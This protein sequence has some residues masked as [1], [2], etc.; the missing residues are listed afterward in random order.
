M[1]TVKF[2]SIYK[3]IGAIYEMYGWC[4]GNIP[5]LPFLY[6]MVKMMIFQ[7]FTFFSYF[8]AFF[9]VFCLKFAFFYCFLTFFH[10]FCKIGV[11]K[12]GYF[13]GIWSKYSGK[14]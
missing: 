7:F 13:D 3:G 11:C 4:N 12:M 14:R 8:D 6:I 9:N 10:V 5:P 1:G 2:L